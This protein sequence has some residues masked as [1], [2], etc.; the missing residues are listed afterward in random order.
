MAALHA[1][2]FGGAG[3]VAVVFLKPGQKV[4]ALEALARLAKG[5]V[6]VVGT[7]ARDGRR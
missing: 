3:D 1:D 7:G 5:Q 4:V 2:A 6:R